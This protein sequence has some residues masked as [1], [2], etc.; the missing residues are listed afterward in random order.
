MNQA[1]GNTQKNSIKK[2]A[3]PGESKGKNKTQRIEKPLNKR[4]Y[5]LKEA[6]IYLGRPVF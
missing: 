4:L 6:A 2:T 1:T 3:G 5:D